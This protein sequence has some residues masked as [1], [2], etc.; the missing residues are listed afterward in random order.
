MHISL[1]DFTASCPKHF[2]LIVSNPPYFNNALKA[3]DEKRKLAR[4]T[5]SLS[6]RSLLTDCKNLLSGH[7]RICLVLPFQEEENIM[8]I[9]SQL[10]LN[11]TALTRVLP[12][13][14]L[15]PK[16]I[17]IEFSK[18]HRPLITNRLTIETENRHCYTP[19]YTELMKN[20]YLKM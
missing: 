11:C 19:A 4:H 3:P 9:A 13:P 6:H 8:N 1:A 18:Q 14:D 17:L 2:D 10:E 12:K 7:G 5:D 16:R 20:Y 15:P